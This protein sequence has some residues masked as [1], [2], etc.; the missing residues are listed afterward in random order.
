[1]IGLFWEKLSAADWAI[2]LGS[3]RRLDGMIQGGPFSSQSVSGM[4]HEITF[5]EVLDF[6]MDPFPMLYVKLF[7]S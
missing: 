5:D 6:P 2:T 1:M 3:T 7:M 4:Q